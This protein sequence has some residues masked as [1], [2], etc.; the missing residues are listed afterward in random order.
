MPGY[1]FSDYETDTHITPIAKGG[2]SP[3][4]YIDVVI[5]V[6]S[7][8]AG[9]ANAP[10]ISLDISNQNPFIGGYISITARVN[11]G[12]SSN[13]SYSWFTNEKWKHRPNHSICQHFTSHFR[14]G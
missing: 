11:D 7:I 3:M 2:V 6:G 10:L 14:S 9:E 12:N 4:E 8:G 1:T 5:N 13:Y